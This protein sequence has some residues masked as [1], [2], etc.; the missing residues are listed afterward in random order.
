MVLCIPRAAGTRRLYT[1]DP[2]GI[3]A[4]RGWLDGF[5]DEALAAFE[6][7]AEEQPRKGSHD[8][9]AEEIRH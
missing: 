5:W 8:D 9:R 4:L 7:A 2:R 3:E 1:V 6:E